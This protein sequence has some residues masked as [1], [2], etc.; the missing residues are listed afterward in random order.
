MTNPGDVNHV[1]GCLPDF[2]IGKRLFFHFQTLLF[3]SKSLILAH[4]QGGGSECRINLHL[5][6]GKVSLCVTWKSSI[7]IIHLFAV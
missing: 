1:S 7:R 5:L 3:G 6:E 2:S 4:A